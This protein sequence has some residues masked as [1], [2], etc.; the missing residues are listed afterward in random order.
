MVFKQKPWVRNLMG[1]IEQQTVLLARIA[2]SLDTLVARSD[3]PKDT[4]PASLNNP[5]PSSNNPPSL[6]N[7]ISFVDLSGN[8]SISL[9]DPSANNS[10]PSTT[11]KNKTSSKDNKASSKNNVDDNK[12]SSKDNV[13]E[14]EASSKDNAK[15]TKTDSKKSKTNKKSKTDKKSKAASKDNTRTERTSEEREMRISSINNIVDCS[16]W[17]HGTIKEIIKD[18]GF[19]FDDLQEWAQSTYKIRTHPSKGFDKWLISVRKRSNARRDFDT[20]L[21]RRLR[22][23]KTE[24]L[25]QWSLW[26]PSEIDPKDEENWFPEQYIRSDTK[27]KAKV[28]MAMKSKNAEIVEETPAPKKRKPQ[29]PEENGGSVN[30]KKKKTKSTEAEFEREEEDDEEGEWME[31]NTSEDDE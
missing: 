3:S 1:L 6:N 4:P 31:H 17:H 28:D 11:K 8:D 21:D 10:P 29:D 27:G 16:N 20:V 23:G 2:A 24:Y 26:D 25:V 5:P 30:R 9:V 13:K 19:S 7:P 22:R 12:T 18:K 14:N 15:K